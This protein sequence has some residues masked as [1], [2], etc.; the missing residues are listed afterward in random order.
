MAGAVFCATSAQLTP[1]WP[2][3]AQLLLPLPLH[4]REALR[5]AQ[6]EEWR[7]W[8]CDV[9]ARDALREAWRD[10]WRDVC[11]VTSP[12]PHS[13]E[14]EPGDGARCSFCCVFLRSQRHLLATYG[15]LYLD[16]QA[17]SP[18]GWPSPHNTLEYT[19][20]RPLGY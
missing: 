15:T 9:F 5:E 19:C 14:K 4:P 13:C 12:S 18:V 8:L 11:D 1:C 20:V 2:V 3:D 17:R 16:L 7:D 10:A 6:R